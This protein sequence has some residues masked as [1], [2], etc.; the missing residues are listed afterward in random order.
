M[1]AEETVREG[2]NMKDTPIK[3]LKET[4]L[5]R[6]AHWKTIGDLGDIW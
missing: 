2:C 1:E 3:R 6:A 5:N 4:R